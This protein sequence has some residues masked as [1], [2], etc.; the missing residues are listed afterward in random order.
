MCILLRHSQ[1]AMPKHT[2]QRQDVAPIHH[3]MRCKGM[4]QHMGHLPFRQLQTDRLNGAAKSV[5]SRRERQRRFES[6]LKP[7]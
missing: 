1:G 6:F 3:V 5:V 4:P 2:L 7:L